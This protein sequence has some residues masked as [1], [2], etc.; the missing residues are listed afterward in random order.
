[1]WAT[2]R[3]SAELVYFARPTGNQQ[4]A[5]KIVRLGG[6]VVMQDNFT[7]VI[8][9]AHIHGSGV[10]IDPAVKCVRLIVEPHTV[11]FG[12]GPGA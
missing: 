3:R 5:S 4:I 12:K 2:P 10:Q 7:G 6:Q 1:M 8:D 9:E 11:Y